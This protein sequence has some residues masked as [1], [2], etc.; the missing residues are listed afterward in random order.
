[1]TEADKIRSAIDNEITELLQNP[2]K[3]AE[4]LI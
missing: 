4:Q 2:N 3:I 1:M